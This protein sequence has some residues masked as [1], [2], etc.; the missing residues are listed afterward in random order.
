MTQMLKSSNKDVKEAI[1]KMLQKL[2]TNY[3]EI[4]GKKVSENNQKMLKKKEILEL[5]NT[6]TSL[7]GLSSRIEMAGKRAS[8]LQGS[9]RDYPI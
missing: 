5:K 2:K 6:M 4:N 7:N 8:E 3:L 1:T 9:N